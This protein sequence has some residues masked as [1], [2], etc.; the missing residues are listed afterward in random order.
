MVASLSRRIRSHNNSNGMEE[1]RLLL[2]QANSVTIELEGHEYFFHRKLALPSATDEEQL[3]LLR[4]CRR[5][6]H[7]QRMLDQQRHMINS[8]LSESASNEDGKRPQYP[9]QYKDSFHIVDGSEAG[10]SQDMLVMGIQFIHAHETEVKQILK[11]DW[12]MPDAIAIGE[13][14]AALDVIKQLREKALAP[15]EYIPEEE[16]IANKRL[17]K[18]ATSLPL[19]SLRLYRALEIPFVITDPAQ[20]SKGLSYTHSGSISFN[21]YDQTLDHRFIAA[22]E[23]AHALLGH[24]FVNNRYILQQTTEYA[25]PAHIGEAAKEFSARAQAIVN[26]DPDIRKEWSQKMKLR[27][28]LFDDVRDVLT[29]LQTAHQNDANESAYESRGH[30]WDYELIC[31]YFALRHANFANEPELMEF[32]S[33]KAAALCDGLEKSSKLQEHQLREINRYY[34]NPERDALFELVQKENPEVTLPACARSR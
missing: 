10:I 15:A 3:T 12:D 22:H 6:V 7:N 19:D 26:N 27:T 34:D 33:P 18:S 11:R 31:N 9:T 25:V 21:Q 2:T 30:A 32:L 4:R 1:D 5:A 20:Q 28:Q 17:K 23:L 29:Q 14:L 24:D 16:I 8:A 13:D